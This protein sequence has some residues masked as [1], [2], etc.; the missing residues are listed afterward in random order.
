MGWNALARIA[1]LRSPRLAAGIAAL[2]R[3]GAAVTDTVNAV[4][5]S[6]CHIIPF[7]EHKESVIIPMVRARGFA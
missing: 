1:Q 7:V 6:V 4:E 2:R 3:V 5:R